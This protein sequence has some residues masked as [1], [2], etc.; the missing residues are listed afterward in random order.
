M[1]FALATV[2]VVMTLRALAVT[3]NLM[4][5]VQCRTSIMMRGPRTE[6]RLSII[7]DVPI[8]MCKSL[9]RTRMVGLHDIITWQYLVPKLAWP[10]AWRSQ[11]MD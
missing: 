2:R 5:G 3:F 1:R 11:H 9:E 6:G 4:N 8:K 10:L 7:D